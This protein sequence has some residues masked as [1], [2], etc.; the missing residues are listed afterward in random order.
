MH[1]LT[2]S[3]SRLRYIVGWLAVPLSVVLIVVGAQRLM[4][5]APDSCGQPTE[6]TI[7]ESKEFTPYESRLSHLPELPIFTGAQEPA[8]LPATARIGTRP[9]T[10]LS[11]QLTIASANG[12][13]YSYFLDRSLGKMSP[14]EFLAAG[15]IQLEQDPVTQDEMFAA[16][17]FV[18]LGNRA[19]A[20][21]V[22]P[23]D[24]ALV[25]ADPLKDGTRSH[26]LYWSDGTYNY[27]VI[28]NRSAEELLGIG[29]GLVC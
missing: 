29:R 14:D 17:I 19:T 25:W 20:V 15:G 23:F 5:A 7:I 26:N 1:T 22:G 27:A 13:I 24:G 16:D 21:R 2:E 11:R 28:A 3:A 9:I 12:S 8:P 6:G 18:E 10:G 4:A